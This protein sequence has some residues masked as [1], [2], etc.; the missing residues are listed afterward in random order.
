MKRNV[1]YVSGAEKDTALDD[2]AGFLACVQRRHA[3]GGVRLAA[4][5]L[6]SIDM[7]L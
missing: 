4:R 1:V 5:Q 6:I 3:K 2:I 7:K